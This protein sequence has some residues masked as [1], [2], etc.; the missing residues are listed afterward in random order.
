MQIPSPGRL[1]AGVSLLAVTACQTAPARPA[2]AQPGRPRPNIIFVM[3]DDQEFGSHATY[4]PRLKALVADRGV[5]F[6]NAFV[7]DPVCGPSRA[8]VLTGQYVHNHGVLDNGP[9]IGGFPKFY[10]TGKE[11]S[12][13]ATWLQA[14]GYRTFLAGK[15]MNFYPSARPG[16]DR[17]V[18][19]GWDEFF[20]VFF[21]E[22]YYEYQ[23]NENHRLVGYQDAPQ[24]Y[25]TD[26][27]AGKVLAFLD[28]RKREDDR[29]FFI[30]LSPFAPHRPAVPAPRHEALF[31]D[32]RPPRS[33]SFNE[34]DVS[35]KP[36]W[37]REGLPPLTPE[38]IEK[39]DEL[40]RERIRTLQAVDEMLERIVRL[41]EEQG[42]L[43]NTYIVYFSD[44]GFQFGAH[45]MPYG[46]GD[47]YEES[48]RVPLIV[49]GPGV[50]AGRTLP[51]MALN[52]DLAPTFAAWAGV[53]PPASVDGRSLLP[54]LGATPLPERSWRGDF[55]VEHWTR[56]RSSGGEPGGIPEY[57]ALRTRDHVYV[58]YVTG[59][60]EL[61]DLK[62]DP[63]Q[64]Q[65]AAVSADPR[66]L[67]RLAGR[68]EELK[69]CSGEGCRR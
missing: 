59:E 28:R 42:E 56:E 51:Q 12:T 24:D 8:S 68:L 7:T 61:Y 36:A 25:L 14:A 67:R 52:I 30:H 3:T 18:P 35:D 19:P 4:M 39:T 43:D 46:K 32:A 41:L 63:W 1:L 17:H 49:R 29:P 64:M 40:F 48:I 33:P 11:R 65:N 47:P 27:V 37:V 45:R 62:R 20:G 66:L 54:L 21:P 58:E 22:S 13:I 34:E 31:P 57:A 69:A 6:S 16:L 26:V 10:D 2:T 5:S 9:P 60:K 15:Y 23:V 55:L 44:N 50:P 53:A 38:E